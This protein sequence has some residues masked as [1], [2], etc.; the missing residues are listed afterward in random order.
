MEDDSLFVGQHFVNKY[1]IWPDMSIDAADIV[2]AQWV[3][4]IVLRQRSCLS[5]DFKSFGEKVKVPTTALCLANILTKPGL[6]LK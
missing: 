4:A 2:A 6:W 1:P 5:Q 3:G